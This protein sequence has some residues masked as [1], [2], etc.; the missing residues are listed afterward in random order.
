[1]K[2]STSVSH[3][4]IQAMLEMLASVRCILKSGSDVHLQT[5][6]TDP[7]NK[8]RFFLFS[9]YVS[10]LNTMCSVV[11]CTGDDLSRVTLCQS[12]VV[13]PLFLRSRFQNSLIESILAV[14]MLLVLT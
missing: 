10:Y 2:P 14:I 1:M 4:G 9:I 7:Q 6:C 5:V 12:L 13:S 8:R 3:H 11:Y